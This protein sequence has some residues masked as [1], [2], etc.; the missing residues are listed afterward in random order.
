MI[1]G[2]EGFRELL[3]HS[4][5]RKI[6][7]IMETPIDI[8]RDNPDNLKV[9]LNLIIIKEEKNRLLLLLAFCFFKYSER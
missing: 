5:I 6:P 9:V 8:R 3:K 2:K 4:A 1:I 7:F